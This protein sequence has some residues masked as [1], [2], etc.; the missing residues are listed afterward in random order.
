MVD[1]I[2]PRYQPTYRADEINMII[3]FARRGESLGFVGIAGVGKSNIVNFLRDIQHNAPH[4]SEDVANL[5]FPVVDATQW[6]NTAAS[7][8]ELMFI[9][10]GQAIKDMSPPQID[11]KVIPFSDDERVFNALQDQ[12]QWVCQ[13]K[14]QKVMFILDDFDQVLKIGPLSMLEKLNVLRSE[15]N[16]GYLSYLVFTKKLPHVLGRHHPLDNH[17]KFYDLFRHDIYAL[18]PY[19]QDDAMRMLQ[20]L[21]QIAGNSL[22]PND[23]QKI[24]RLAGGHARLLKLVFEV[25][26]KE[27]ASGIKSTYFAQKND[28]Q[29]ECKRILEHLHV[30]EQQAAIRAAQGKS[31]AEDEYVLNHLLYR[32]I[33]LSVDPV[34][35]FSPIMPQ[36]LSSKG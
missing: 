15:G 26:L 13:E 8:W 14:K 22:S 23:L 30:E 24:Y 20:H 35:W 16:R 9:A 6:Q 17:S 2:I 29:Q 5:R 34:T 31:V 7:L 10:L 27:G 12:L 18:E 28:I 3:G 36:Y 11:P 33:L 19:S 21:N 4:T 25:W 1:G 32:G